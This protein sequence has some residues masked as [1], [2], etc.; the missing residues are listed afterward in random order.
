[1]ILGFSDLQLILVWLGML[2]FAVLGIAVFFVALY[3][4]VRNAVLAAL[5]K[6]DEERFPAQMG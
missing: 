3:F 6:H 5:R 1:M 4:V 2:L